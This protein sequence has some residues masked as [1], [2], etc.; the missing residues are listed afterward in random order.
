M[1]PPPPRQPP[2]SDPGRGP[3]THNLTLNATVET[4]AS[5][6]ALRDATSQDGTHLD[7]CERDLLTLWTE[8]LRNTDTE[9]N[10]IVPRM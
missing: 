3:V 9:G 6:S 8:N 5:D 4:I 2:P 1:P 10:I 7:S